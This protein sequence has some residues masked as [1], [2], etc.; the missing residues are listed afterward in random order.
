MHKYIFYVICDNRHKTEILIEH[1]L[2]N[3]EDVYNDFMHSVD[4]VNRHKEIADRLDFLMCHC[5]KNLYIYGVSNHNG[6]GY[7]QCNV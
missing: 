3:F 6:V 2:N 7:V 4:K 5:G 1:K